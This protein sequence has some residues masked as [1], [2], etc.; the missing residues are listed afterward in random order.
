[1]EEIL[2]KEKTTKIIEGFKNRV[3]VENSVRNV[4]IRIDFNKKDEKT[5]GYFFLTEKPNLPKF[6]PN[7]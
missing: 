6:L 1:M 2:N 7:S 4:H 3:A 5:S